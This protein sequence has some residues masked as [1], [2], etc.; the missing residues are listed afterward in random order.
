MPLSSTGPKLRRLTNRSKQLD[1]HRAGAAAAAGGAAGP[2]A[3][4]V[5]L[6]TSLLL[7]LNPD[8]GDCSATNPLGAT[9]AGAGCPG[10][11]GGATGTP[12][13]I[14]TLSPKP[15]AAR[16]AAPKLIPTNDGIT[17]AVDAFTAEL[18]SRF[19]LG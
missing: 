12:P 5:R 19:T 16:L 7:A 2:A 6:I 9:G 1:A 11:T 15:I 17:N 3:R 10:K 13:I 14:A 8:S 4:I 18:S